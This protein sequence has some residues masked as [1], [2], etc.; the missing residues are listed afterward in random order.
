MCS[1]LVLFIS[2]IPLEYN[3][4]VYTTHSQCSN[5]IVFACPQ[6]ESESKCKVQQKKCEKRLAVSSLLCC[7]FKQ[8][9]NCCCL[10]ITR[11]ST[12]WVPR[13]ERMVQSRNLTTFEKNVILR[14]MAAVIQPNKVRMC[15]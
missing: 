6:R 1:T 8:C 11:Q 15:D 7:L 5:V 10:Q 9:Y 13:L 14:L 2:Q 4:V 12:N 3:A